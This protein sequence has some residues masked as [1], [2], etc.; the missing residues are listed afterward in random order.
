MM[1]LALGIA[2][3]AALVW[4]GRGSA[5]NGSPGAWRIVSGLTALVAFTG[6]GLLLMRGGWIKS[7]PLMALG[8]GFLLAARRTRRSRPASHMR[9]WMSETEARAMLGVSASADAAEIETA[10]RRLMKRVH[11]DH[12]GASGLAVQLNAARDVLLKL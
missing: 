6:T 9:N 10:Y 5:P 7:V 1:D 2:L 8:L 11:P 4:L 12:G 3:L